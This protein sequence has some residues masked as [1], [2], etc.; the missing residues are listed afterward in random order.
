M[1]RRTIFEGWLLPVALV[2][3]QLIITLFFFLLPSD[4]AFWSSAFLQ[5]PFGHSAQFVGLENF[6][7]L[8]DDPQYVQSVVRTIGFVIPVTV[9]A[10]AVALL[11]GLFVDRE[12]RG[13]GI[14]RT[15]L[16]WPYAV[17]PAVAGVL[18]IFLMRPHI[19]LIGPG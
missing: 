3:P 17:A 5:D 1:K 19:G 11:L 2:A 18:W 10:L 15:L 13:K 14:Y 7:H 8:F 9:V 6:W 4:E 12:I 16:I